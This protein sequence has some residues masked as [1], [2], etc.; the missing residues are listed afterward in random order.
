MRSLPPAGAVRRW[1]PPSSNLIERWR[2][3]LA[4]NVALR[5]PKLDIYE[6]NEAVQKI[7]DRIVFLRIAE[8]RQSEPFKNLFKPTQKEN[9]YKALVRLFH[10]ADE[11]YNSGL[12]E[13]KKLLDK[14]II[15]DRVIKPIITGLY[16]TCPYQFSEI[17]IEI[18]GSVYERFLGKSIR[19]TEGH[20]AKVEEKP[21]VR[22]AG[23]VYYTPEYIVRYIVE[24]TIDEKL[25]G[26]KPE[27]YRNGRR[28]LTVCDPACGSG[29]FLVGVYNYL[30]EWYRNSYTADLK[31]LQKTRNRR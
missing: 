15:D 3:E 20:R 28:S 12:F 8:D 18:L 5:N 1:I 23:G 25:K 13:N 2:E 11:K 14:L 31:T 6:I 22:K 4:R 21:E 16:D 17:P 19:L 29:S 26:R 30:L 10:K 24:N 27:E 9:I 7:I